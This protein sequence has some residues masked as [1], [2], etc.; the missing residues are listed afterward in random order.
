MVAGRHAETRMNIQDA[1]LIG[2]K[3]R[4]SEQAAT[5]SNYSIELTKNKA[6]LRA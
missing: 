2:I 3:L 6:T 1:G 5:H 4:I